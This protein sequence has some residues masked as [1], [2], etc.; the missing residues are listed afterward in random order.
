MTASSYS[1]ANKTG[2]L[3][4][5]TAENDQAALSML[6]SLADANPNSG[7]MREPTVLSSSNGKNVINTKVTPIVQ[8]GTTAIK[9]STTQTSPE[10]DYGMS[11]LE[12]AEARA[13]MQEDRDFQNTQDLYKKLAIANTEDAM[14]DIG[15]I[16]GMWNSSRKAQ[17]DANKMGE[18]IY[19]Q[20][21]IRGGATRYAPE[22]QADLMTDVITEGV[23]RLQDI[24]MKYQSAISKARSAMKS[25]NFQLALQAA[26]E[27]KEYHG[28]ALEEI[29]SQKEVAT[30][31]AKKAQDAKRKVSRES[32][33]VGLIKQ[34]VTDPA[35]LYDYLNYDDKGEQVG[36]ITT[37]EIDG[38]LKNIVPKE[39]ASGGFKF[40][41]DDVGK[42]IGSGLGAQDIQQMQD[43]LNEGGMDF[44]LAGLSG[45][46]KATV[47]KIL[48][49][50]QAAPGSVGGT[51][52]ISEARG[53]GLPISL[54]GRSQSQI[55]ADLSASNPP[56]WFIDFTEEKSRTSM[57]MD[58]LVPLWQEFR[59]AVNDTFISGKT[60]GAASSGAGDLEAEID[61][62][63][64]G[65]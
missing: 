15:S 39:S 55:L 43:D 37:D 50:V 53:L 22:M 17:Q 24:D 33:I 3:S 27:A 51:L 58:A 16:Q 59:G 1:Y 36:D 30:E 12:D 56:R 61:A 65:S 2:G 46:Q 60:A 9:N 31:F 5:L 26:R 29:Q 7:V 32:A 44:V 47:S 4:T 23:S 35:K 28:K 57:T 8:E 10:P 25:N 42:L 63:F 62:A 18:A 6:G 40:S 11:D 34:G 19:Q 54:V 49:G 45:P 20:A 21:G 14:A 41:N 13:R 38:V 52:T 64:P 48:N